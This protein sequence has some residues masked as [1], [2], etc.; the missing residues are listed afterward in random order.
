MSQCW[1]QL[2]CKLLFCKGWLPFRN[3]ILVFQ[4]APKSRFGCKNLYIFQGC[5]KKNTDSAKQNMPSFGL[6]AIHASS[7]NSEEVPLPQALKTKCILYSGQQ[8]F[9][10]AATSAIS[11]GSTELAL[12]VVSVAF[13]CW[14]F[15][16]LRHFLSDKGER[17]IFDPLRTTVQV[18]QTTGRE[19]RQEE[20]ELTIGY[21]H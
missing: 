1:L 6:C 12:G 8:A 17:Q 14:H 7:R 15:P 13:V 2:N 3:A 10:P 4:G 18:L 21:F 11:K 20:T 16:S 5:K 19:F 9:V